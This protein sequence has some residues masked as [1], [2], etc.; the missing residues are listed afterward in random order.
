MKDRID[1]NAVVAWLVKNLKGKSSDER[2]PKLINCD[3]AK[4]GVTL[5]SKNT[6]L[7]TTKK[8]LAKPRFATLIPIVGLCHIVVSLRRVNNTL[9]HAVRE[10][11]A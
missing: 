11:A 5:D 6:C 1:S 10:P 7:D 8:V 2:P 9:N 4:M 3:R